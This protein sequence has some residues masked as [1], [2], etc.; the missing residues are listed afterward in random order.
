MEGLWA[1]LQ[2][3]AA[4]KRAV[5][6]DDLA[7]EQLKEQVL[8]WVDNHFKQFESIRVWH[9]RSAE[10]LGKIEEFAEATKDGKPGPIERHYRADASGVLHVCVPIRQFASQVD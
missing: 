1:E 9:E 5:L 8:L 2:K 10:Y 4:A 6:D 7:R 3:G